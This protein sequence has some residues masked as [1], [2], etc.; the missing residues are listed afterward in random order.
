MSDLIPFS[1]SWKN[2]KRKDHIAFLPIT[3]TPHRILRSRAT[4][5]DVYVSKS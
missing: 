5:N 2:R 4:M 3:N 1:L